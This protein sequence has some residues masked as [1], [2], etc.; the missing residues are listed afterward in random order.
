MPNPNPMQCF[1]AGHNLS[2]VGS[3]F[4]QVLLAAEL[5]RSA[6]PKAKEHIK[7]MIAV[8]QK[9]APNF[10]HRLKEVAQVAQYCDLPKRKLPAHP[11]DYK[12][13]APRVHMDF[14]EVWDIDDLNGWLFGH[15]FAVGELRNLLIVLLISMDFQI[16]F[17][18]HTT[19]R[20]KVIL[21]RGKETLSRYELSALRLEG[22][23]Q[24]DIFYEKSLELAP[25]FLQLLEMKG[26]AIAFF[27][28]SQTLLAS[29]AEIEKE[30]LSDW[31]ADVN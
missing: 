18:I 5:E 21:E 11:P 24:F 17:D 9:V 3:Y 1:I 22:S 10:V 6:H 31:L 19:D 25:L 20:L 2:Y 16:N 13:W 27:A 7:S 15:A 28:K 12:D 8:L 29:F 30:A 23:R 14:L 4:D 26:D